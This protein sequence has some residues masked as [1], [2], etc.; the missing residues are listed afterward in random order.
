MKMYSEMYHWNEMRAVH[1]S[2]FKSGVCPRLG[3]E[4]SL[5]LKFPGSDLWKSKKRII[6]PLERGV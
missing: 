5:D 6:V 3:L 1:T 4:K 2:A